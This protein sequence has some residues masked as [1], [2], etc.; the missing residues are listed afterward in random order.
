MPFPFL[1][2]GTAAASL[3]G[4]VISNAM[5]AREAKR[6]RQFQERMSSTAHQREV[7]DLRAANINPSLRSLGGA[8]TPGGDRA[9]MQDFVS[10]GVS[11]ALA[12]RMQKAQ[13]DLV[14]AQAGLART[15]AADI[16]NTAAAGRLR[17]ITADA[18]AKEMT[19][20][21]LRESLPVALAQAKA[22]VQRT[23][24]SAEAARAVAFLDR[25]AA[26]GAINAQEFEQMI[27]TA[28]P[29]TKFLLNVI[30]TLGRSRK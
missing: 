22:E 26:A 1:Q 30:Q 25:A 28:G 18:D 23:L 27:G 19:T 10:K 4:G 16:A 6:N 7:A 14:S 11:S 17:G 12:V 9:E 8:S 5:N 29:W 13:I 2:V 20:A 24:A 21:Q 15:Q 3:L